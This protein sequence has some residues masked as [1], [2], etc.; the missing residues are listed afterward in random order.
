MLDLDV[1]CVGGGG[2]GGGGGGGG[3]GSTT[4]VRMCNRL[5]VRGKRREPK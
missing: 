5:Y 1:G 2:V 3:G 4:C